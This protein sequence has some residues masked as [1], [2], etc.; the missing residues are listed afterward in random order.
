MSAL[1]AAICLAHTLAVEAISLTTNASEIA[2]GQAVTVSWSGVDLKRAVPVKVE[3]SEGDDGAHAWSVTTRKTQSLWIGQF[4]PPIISMNDVHMGVDPK[5]HGI[6][7]E[8]TPPFTE[9]AP[10]K[11][12]S[13][14]QLSAGSYSF[15]VTNMRAPVNWVLFAG[16]LDDPAGFNVLAVSKPVNLVD[17]GAPMHVRLARTSSVDEMRVSWTSAQQDGA[18][19]VKFGTSAGVL[20]HAVSAT[21]HT[22][23]AAD[24]CGFPANASGW[25][26]PVRRI[27]SRRGERIE[28][29]TRPAMTSNRGRVSGSLEPK[30]R[31]SELC[32]GIDQA[33]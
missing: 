19:K 14:T 1:V 5:S 3:F 18:H 10:V 26:H 4:S 24:L 21:T 29:I 32:D 8:G 11:F 7:T 30:A 9:P 13:G 28:R 23:A 17:A 33:P 22:Y 27:G 12:I 31:V 2:S 25:H 15:V 20:D 6:A 16:A